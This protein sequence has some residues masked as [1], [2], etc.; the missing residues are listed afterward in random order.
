MPTARRHCPT[1]G[2]PEFIT[3]KQRRCSDCGRG[4][5]KRRGTRQ[6]RGYDRSYD[7]ERRSYEQT[8][9]VGLTC[10]RCGLKL[11][12]GQPWDL[13]HNDERTA[14]TGPEHVHCNRSAGGISAH[15]K[16]PP[17]T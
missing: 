5:E 3:G 15:R 12:A 17:P 4:Y 6:Q 11:L 9:V 7:T 2:C 1:P 14:I 10:P 16:P 8:G 13:G